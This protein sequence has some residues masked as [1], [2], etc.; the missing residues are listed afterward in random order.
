[1]N[2]YDIRSEGDPT[3]GEPEQVRSLARRAQEN[4]NAF[5][6]ASTAASGLTPDQIAQYWEGIAADSFIQRAAELEPELDRACES[7]NQLADAL[8]G[9]A[10]DL[11]RLQ[12]KSGALLARGVR[13]LDQI[14]SA[15]SNLND[16]AWQYDYSTAPMEESRRDYLRP[17]E[18]SLD[19]WDDELRI[20]RDHA[21]ELENELKDVASSRAQQ[22]VDASD[23]GF[24]GNS[25]L[26]YL[27]TAADVVWDFAVA[28]AEWV[29]ELAELQLE[30]MMSNAKLQLTLLQVLAGY[31][32]GAELMAAFEDF[33]G[34]LAELLDHLEP[35][36]AI[37]GVVALVLPPPAGP[38]LATV[39]LTIELTAL[40]VD[41]TR[42]V[43]FP[44]EEPP[45]KSWGEI[46]FDAVLTLAP[47]AV[48]AGGH[49]LIKNQGELFNSQMDFLKATD[50]GSIDA[51]RAMGDAIQ[52]SFKIRTTVESV[53][54]LA[55]GVGL[56]DT[57]SEYTNFDRDTETPVQTFVPGSIPVLELEKITLSIDE[58]PPLK[59]IAI[60]PIELA[61]LQEKV[62]PHDL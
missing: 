48:D 35:V 30:F 51:S 53:D 11:E 60:K 33:T 21:E 13:A 15:Q 17:Y 50:L 32:S 9:W 1:M 34:D 20:V 16:A 45:P 38:I 46:G 52:Q 36:L 27:A 5:A 18:E 44:E 7:F 26:D 23:A 57:L 47:E 58:L 2:W 62:D 12:D 43:A 55:A 37:A 4:A 31:G 3:R 22:I 10:G 40:A 8:R 56:G 59:P 42:K 61:L 19:V 41:I 49:K 14:R 6:N 39:L 28:L 54:A 24:R 25:L 29:V